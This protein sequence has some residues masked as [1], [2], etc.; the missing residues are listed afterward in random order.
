MKKFL[1]ISREYFISI[2][3]RGIQSFFPL[4]VSIPRKTFVCRLLSCN[5]F[6]CFWFQDNVVLTE[7]LVMFFP[8]SNISEIFLY[9]FLPLVF[10]R[11][12]QWS[13]HKLHCYSCTLQ[14][15]VF[16]VFIIIQFNISTNFLPWLLRLNGII[17]KLRQIATKMEKSRLRW[18]KCWK[19]RYWNLLVDRLWGWGKLIWRCLSKVKCVGG[20]WI[21]K[22]WPQGG[23]VVWKWIGNQVLVE[24]LFLSKIYFHTKLKVSL[25]YYLKDIG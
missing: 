13:F 1:Y 24:T 21:Y 14:M 18:K 22:S 8:F 19:E 16:C 11:V 17:E 9:Y 12:N 5:I 4:L 10:G 3:F 15:S 20:S 2:L 25:F 7:W 23:G 6:V